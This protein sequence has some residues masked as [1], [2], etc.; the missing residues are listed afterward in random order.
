MGELAMKKIAAFLF[1]L[2]IF[3]Y[4][5]IAD[6]H[7]TVWPKESQVGAWEKYTVRVPSEKDS[8]TVKVK[9]EFPKG[10]NVETVEPEPGWDYRFIKGND[11]RNVAIEWSATAGGIKPHEFMEFA[12][13]G[14]NPKE[15][16]EV[17]WKAYQTYSDGSVVEWTGTPDSKTPASVTKITATPVK[18][19][20]TVAT[21]SADAE[22]QTSKWN[23][24]S[25]GVAGLA[26]LLSLISL[27]RKN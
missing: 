23:F 12:F 11:G 7:V 8:N 24:I 9:L 1:G 5:G 13:I 4:V 6:A 27:F 18:E 16:G 21:P 22:A 10:V 3:A 26:L 19:G 17:A 2:S 20:Q 14:A 25:L 15:P